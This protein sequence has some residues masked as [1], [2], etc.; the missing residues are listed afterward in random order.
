MR[1]C[2]RACLIACKYV[3]VSVLLV[4]FL[5]AIYDISYS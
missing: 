4:N 1:A 2:V 3:Y 5:C